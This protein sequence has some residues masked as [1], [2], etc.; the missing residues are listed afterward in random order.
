MKDAL[1]IQDGMALLHILTNMPPTFGEI[2]LQILDQMVAKKHFLFSTDSYHPQSIKAQ[3]RERRGKSEKIIVDGPSTRKPGDF[4]Q[5]LANDDNKK[6]LCQLLFRVWSDQR[7]ASRLEKTDMAVL[8]VEGRAH[9]LTS[10]NG[11]VEAH[12]IHTIYSN[13]EETDTRVVLY[14]HH[15]AAIGYKDAVVRTPDTDIFVILLYHAH[16]I[17]LNVYLDTGSG[18]HRRLINVTEFAESLGK[19]Y[20]A[21]LLGYYVWSGEDCTSAFKGKGK[22]GPLKKLQKNPKFQEAFARLGDEWSIHHEVDESLEQFACVMYGHSRELS[23]NTVRGKML[24]KMVG[25]DEKLTAK[26]KV[27]LARLPPCRAALQPHNKRVNHRVALY[28]RAHIAIVE[29]PKPYDEGQGWMRNAKDLLEP[30]WSSKPILPASLID[31]LAAIDPKDKETEDE[32]DMEVDEVDFDAM[33][34]SDEEL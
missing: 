33:F 25:E 32:E 17:K 4:K 12:E 19:N 14:L 9:K 26:S 8:I 34:E 23:V 22:V 21:A 18:K 28:K 3:E 27:D 31:L 15:A 11:K 6:Q 29:K 20:C 7:A 1:F 10:S 5:F 30:I 13:Q 2:C 16:E 24:R